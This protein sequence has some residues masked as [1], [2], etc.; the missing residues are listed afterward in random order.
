MK[1]WATWTDMSLAYK[2]KPTILEEAPHNISQTT[3]H[4]DFKGR[5]QVLPCDVWI[6]SSLCEQIIYDITIVRITGSMQAVKA[7][8]SNH[9]QV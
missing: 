3:I 7:C 6:N 2:F 9:I 5:P 4:S 1:S 8:W